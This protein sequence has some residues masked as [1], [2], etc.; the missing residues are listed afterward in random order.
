MECTSGVLS[1]CVATGVP[2][3]APS[4][5][6]PAEGLARLGCGTFFHELSLAGIL[7]AVDEAAQD[8][9]A[10]VARARA[11]VLLWHAGNGTNRLAAWIEAQAGGHA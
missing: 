9:P 6:L 4:G 8:F 2:V 1:E 3:I 7:D 5:C 10:L 11:A